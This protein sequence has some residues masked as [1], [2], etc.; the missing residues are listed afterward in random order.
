MT[1]KGFLANFSRPFHPRYLQQH[2]A[3]QTLMKYSKP[4][5]TIMTNSCKRHTQSERGVIYVCSTNHHFTGFPLN[6]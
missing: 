4:N 3:A 1:Q 5:T 2:P 6:C